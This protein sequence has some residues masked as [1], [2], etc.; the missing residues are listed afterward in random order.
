[1]SISDKMKAVE[2]QAQAPTPV[3]NSKAKTDASAKNAAFRAKGAALRAGMSE[4]QKAVE[5]SK[6]DKVKFICALGDPNKK[7]S[8][9]EGKASIDSFVVVGY[10][11]KVLE[12]MTVPNAPLKQDFTSLIDTEPS[13]EVAVKAGQEVILNIAELGEFISREEFAGQFTG[14]GEEVVITAKNAQNRP[15]PLP[16]LK[17]LSGVGSIKAN[18]ELI[19][20]MVGA[21]DGKKGTPKIKDEF[22]EKFGV[23]YTKKSAGKKSTGGTAKNNGEAAA[24]IAAA[25]RALYASKKA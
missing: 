23:L 12:D 5:G 7:Q 14:E 22:K 4:D 13:T 2:A 3:Q 24:D 8:R 11:V 10:K 16:V 17:K 25:F 9:K 20:D 1:M 19:A 6:R 15:E 21:G 18:M